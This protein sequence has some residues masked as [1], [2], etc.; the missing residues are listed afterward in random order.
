MTN[1]VR[2]FS[3]TSRAG[4]KIIYVEYICDSCRRPNTTSKYN[5]SGR[6]NPI[7]KSCRNKLNGI[8]KRGQPSCKKGKKQPRGAESANWNGG[9]YINKAGYVMVLIRHGS[10]GRRSGWE[11]YRPE[12][13]VVIEENLQR[14]LRKD[15]C[16]HHID[17]DKANN[18]PENLALISTNE[19]HRRTHHSLQKIGYD[20]YKQGLI[21]FNRDSGEY[22]LTK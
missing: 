10:I 15:E 4:K 17:G 5:L 8:Q 7:C 2:E 20:L 18:K 12:H 19:H 16:I 14:K 22:E 13:I 3:V 6:S 1:I 21:H 11:N 9:R